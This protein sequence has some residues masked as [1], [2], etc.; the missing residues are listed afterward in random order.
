[1]PVPSTFCGCLRGSKPSRRDRGAHREGRLRGLRGRRSLL[2]L[3]PTPREAAAAITMAR[4]WVAQ[5]TAA[6][7]PESR[8]GHGKLDPVATVGDQEY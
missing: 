6:G 1:M 5:M 4:P 2:G 7:C 3:F 8:V